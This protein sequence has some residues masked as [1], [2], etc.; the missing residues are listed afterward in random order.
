MP[1]RLIDISIPLEKAVAADPPGYGPSIEYYTHRQTV[2]ELIEFF[3]GLREADL[4]DREGWAIEWMRLS[5]HNTTHL[6]A[7]WHF[8][9]RHASVSRLT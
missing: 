8:A 5:T 3:P 7:P 4:P 9:V 2:P 1:R 6:D